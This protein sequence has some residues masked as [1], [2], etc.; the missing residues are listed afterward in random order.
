MKDYRLWCTNT[1]TPRLLIEKT[2]VFHESALLSPKE[3]FVASNDTDSQESVSKQVELEIEH[4]QPVAV[5]V[6]MVSMKR[7]KLLKKNHTALPKGDQGEQLSQIQGM[8]TQQL[9]MHFQW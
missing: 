4:P 1:K 9:H 2:V 8:L 3:D 7:M 6:H 5:D